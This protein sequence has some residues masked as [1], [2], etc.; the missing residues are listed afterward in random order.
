MKVELTL[1]EI[2]RLIDGTVLGDRS[3]RISRLW[4]IRQAIF[5]DLSFV[6][7]PKYLSSVESC[8]ASAL[9]VKADSKIEYPNLI[10]VKNP[11][12]AIAQITEHCTSKNPEWPAEIDPTAIIDSRATIYPNTRIGKGVHIKAGAVIGSDGF[13]FERKENRWV[14]V[15][16]L[17]SVVIEDDV[18]IGANTCIDRARLGET[19]IGRGTKIDNLVQIGHGV[20]I[21]EDC[22]ICGCTG[23]AGS[24]QIGDRV[25]IGGACDIGDGIEIVSDTAIGGSS[26]IFS[27]ILES[28]SYWGRG[29][30]KHKEELK[31]QALYRRLP[32]LF[33]NNAPS[34]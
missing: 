27:P 13:G 19:R 30:I 14:K 10:R 2:A 25:I 18:E 3:V 7:S 29:P 5:G 32:E 22:L 12:L 11:N 33:K 28:G 1:E 17:G 15:P 26:A 23:I 34:K 4:P 16:E 6:Y 9:I 8:K 20:Y 31:C 21:G 24:A